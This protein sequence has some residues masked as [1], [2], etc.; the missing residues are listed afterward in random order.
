MQNQN[1]TLRGVF[2]NAGRIDD[3]ESI[4]DLDGIFIAS[5]DPGSPDEPVRKSVAFQVCL[6]VACLTDA[7]SDSKTSR[8]GY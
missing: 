4:A 1:L 2:Q 6:H 5:G 7:F 3:Y 8:H